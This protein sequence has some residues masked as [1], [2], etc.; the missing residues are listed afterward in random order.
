MSDPTQPD[1]IDAPI[2]YRLTAKAHAA[3]AAAAPF[4]VRSAH[5][6]MYAVDYTDATDDE[7]AG[8]DWWNGLSEPARIAHKVYLESTGIEH[9]SAADCWDAHKRRTSAVLK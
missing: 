6:I 5:G 8:M 4:T 9:A 2:P 3:R 7:R 1:D